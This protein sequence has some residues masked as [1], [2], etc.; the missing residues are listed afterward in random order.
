MNQFKGVPMKPIV[1]ETLYRFSYLSRL[2]ASPNEQR[3]GVVVAK[4]NKKTNDYDHELY[5]DETTPVEVLKL[6]TKQIICLSV[7]RKYS[8]VLTPTR[9]VARRIRP[10]VARES[11]DSMW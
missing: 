7:M 11:Q 4:A 10:N 2:Q 6:G 8:S 9:N 5:V 1:N 3:F